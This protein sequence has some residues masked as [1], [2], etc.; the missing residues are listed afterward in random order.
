MTKGS[1]TCLTAL[2]ILAWPSWR[3]AFLFYVQLLM[4]FLRLNVECFCLTR[5]FVCRQFSCLLFC[6]K[7]IKLS[8]ELLDQLRLFIYYLA[9]LVQGILEQFLAAV[10]LKLY[11]EGLNKGL[12][13]NL[14][15]YMTT[16]TRQ[17]SSV[18]V[19]V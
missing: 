9:D 4:G 3:R 8:I 15:C 18:F 2:V 11:V 16:V 17:I 12:F 19:I 13:N 14:F 7:R 6:Q 1:F 10:L 5:G